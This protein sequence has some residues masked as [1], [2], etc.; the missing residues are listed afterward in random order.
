MKKLF[1]AKKWDK[2]GNVSKIFGEDTKIARDVLR[3]CVVISHVDGVY[4]RE[5]KSLVAEY[6][7]MLGVD[8][9]VV[10][11]IELHVKKQFKLNFEL[12][13]IINGGK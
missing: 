8:D 2:I 1:D 3:N 10:K 9:S 4:S 7:K 6:A 5:E 13:K 11:S 12:Q